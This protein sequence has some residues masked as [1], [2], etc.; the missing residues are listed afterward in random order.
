MFNGNTLLALIIIAGITYSITAKK[1]TVA[2]AL[3]GGVVAYLVFTGAGFTGVAMMTS[4]F[5][6]GSAATSWQSNKKQA[7]AS[8]EEHQSGRTTGQV[9]ANAGIPA[10]IGILVLFYPR[11]SH[12]FKLMMAASFASATADTLSSELGTVYG[13]RFF[14]II[15]L[16]PDQR[17][18]DGV[19]SIE[20]TLIG[21]AGSC[22]IALIYAI[23]FGWDLNLIWIVVAGTAGNLSDSILGALMERKSLIGNNT[24]N[25]LNTFIAALVALLFYFI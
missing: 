20:G 16:K 2:A 17:G 9:L 24:V 15:T 23:G 4:F 6:L 12:L 5:I 7:F 18:L 25:F 3:T 10:V 11:Y 13:T 14:N 1:L 21:I 19:V 22:I 8:A